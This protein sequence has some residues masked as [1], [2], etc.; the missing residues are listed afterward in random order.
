MKDATWPSSRTAKRGSLQLI[1]NYVGE[2]QGQYPPTPWRLGELGYHTCP[3]VP[4]E[5]LSS[6]APWKLH[7]P[8][9][10][11]HLA[12]AP[13]GSQEIRVTLRTQTC[14][15]AAITNFHKVASTG[16]F[17]F[18]PF[19]SQSAFYHESDFSIL[20]VSSGAQLVLR[21]GKLYQLTAV[22]I[23]SFWFGV[24]FFNA[25]LVGREKYLLLNQLV[26]MEKVNK[27]SDT[28][29][30]SDLLRLCFCIHQSANIFSL[31]LRFFEKTNKPTKKTPQ[32]SP[33]NIQKHYRNFQKVLKLLPR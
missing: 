29:P 11:S 25:M 24:F 2:T 22:E 4:G 3:S 16:L 10:S 6:A 18:S 13:Q 17:S 12:E 32:K 8:Y 26:Y 23:L 20:N 19:P 28:S 27:L 14:A 33:K 1:S 5:I 21:S 31:M 15:C 7:V 9:H 30:S